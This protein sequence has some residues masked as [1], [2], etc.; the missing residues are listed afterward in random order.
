MSKEVGQNGV[1]GTMYRVKVQATRK[2]GKKATIKGIVC[3]VTKSEAIEEA[4]KIAKDICECSQCISS[5]KFKSVKEI[6]HDFMMIHK[7]S[8]IAKQASEENPNYKGVT[9]RGVDG[10]TIE[11]LHKDPMLGLL[12]FLKKKLEEKRA[13]QEAEKS[14]ADG[15]AR[16]KE[17][18]ACREAEVQAKAEAKESAIDE[19]K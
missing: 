1:E 3:G 18:N 16:A 8:T 10:G 6:T 9:S 19:S 4:M 12:Q 11:G 13:Q 17:E 2:D 15:V 7:D 5:I 14:Y